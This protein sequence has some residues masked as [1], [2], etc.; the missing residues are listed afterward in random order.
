MNPPPVGTQSSTRRPS[1]ALQAILQGLKPGQKI[2]VTQQVRVGRQV[3]PAVAVGE[4]RDLNY[5]A[6]GVTGDR[7]PQDDIVVATL[8]FKKENGEL[9][10][11]A[12]DE[13][14]KVEVMS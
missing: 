4:F 7:V 11:V 12:L 2:R 14:S 10:S 9:S 6:T 5:L 3:W 13:N 1:P 8:H